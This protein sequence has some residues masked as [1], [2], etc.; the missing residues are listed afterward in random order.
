MSLALVI[1]VHDDAE[2]LAALLAQVAA[3]ELFE[4]VIVVDDASARPVRLPRNAPASW[5]VLRLEQNGGAGAARNRGLTEIATDH[6]LFFDS[7]DRLTE[8][9][10]WLWEELRDTGVAFDFCLFRH[11][12][13]RTGAQDRRGQMDVD[14]AL[15]RQAAAGHGTLFEIPFEA[16]S[17]LAETANYPWNKIYRTGFLHDAGLRFSQTPVHNDVLFHWLSFLR[18]GP[19]LASDRIAAE[20]RVNA[21]GYRLTNRG[22]AERL[23]LFDVLDATAEVLAR[24]GPQE[25][26]VAIPLRLSFFAFVG[27]LIDWARN[28][29]DAALWPAHDARAAAFLEAHLEAPLLA[30]LE[31]TRPEAAARL[32]T[33]QG[34]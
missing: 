16:R 17:T 12:D 29:T 11:H 13:S 32:R 21:D 26:E 27:G 19:I 15:W 1:P 34:A 33:Q 24:P 7:D 9:F 4:Q 20:H 18:A 25:V 6:V 23:Y 8:E 5:Q 22:S 2:N 3:W 10:P 30:Q 31:L 28:V 14:D